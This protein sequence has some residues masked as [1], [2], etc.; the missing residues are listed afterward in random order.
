MAGWVSIS[1]YA[2]DEAT[3]DET[4]HVW[5]IHLQGRVQGVGFRPYVYNKAVAL[6]LAGEVSNGL[7]GV[8]IRLRTNKKVAWALANDIVNNPPQQAVV[9]SYYLEPEPDKIFDG[10]NIVQ[11]TGSKEPNLW[12]TPDFALCDSCKQE[13]ENPA[14]RRFRYPFITCTNCGPRYSVMQALP[15][16]RHLTTM[17]PFTFCISCQQEFDNPADRRFYAQTM[18]CPACGVQMVFTDAHGIV[19]STGDSDAIIQSVTSA[20]QEGSI[21][22]VKG[23]GGF[24]LMTDA[25]NETA[26]TRLRQRKHRPA[27]P[28]A[29]M[30]PALEHLAKDTTLSKEETALLGSPEAPIV[31]L[32]ISPS[33][34]ESLATQ[35]LCPGLDKVGIMLPYAP[36]LHLIVQSFGKPLVATSGNVSGAP[37]CYTNDSAL[38]YLKDVADYFLLHNRDIVA[39]QDDSVVSVTYEKYPAI[40]LRRSR[41]YAPACEVYQTRSPQTV[42]ATGALMK[43]SFAIAHRHRVY[44]SQYLGNTD[45]YEAQQA[46][47]HTLGHMQQLL[48]CSP[49]VVIA[50]AHPNYFS[51]HLAK[52]L[53][54]A[55]NIPVHTVQHHKA[56]FAAALAE[57]DFANEHG[58]GLGIIWDGT[59]LGDDGNSWGGEFFLFENNRMQRVNHFANTPYF[60]GDKMA[61]EPR[62]SALSQLHTMA[63]K[64]PELRSMFTEQEWH[65]YHQMLQQYKGIYTSSVGRLFDA[66]A[67]IITGIGRQSYEGEAAMRLEAMANS[68]C[69]THGFQQLE[70]F[71]PYMQP[72]APIPSNTIL[73]NIIQSLKRGADPS[74]IAARFHATLRDVVGRLAEHYQQEHLFF[75]GGV[76]QNALLVQ[77]LIDKYDR[78][79]HLHFHKQLSPNDENIS[80]G[81]LVYFDT[82]IL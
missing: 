35:A 62:I 64:P 26:I 73:F 23:I 4:E 47:L 2:H 49:E 20:L 33:M 25:T 42:L 44:V 53:S 3:D 32:N 22:A 41:G 29:I 11:D 70:T 82:Q 63:E 58:H 77:M 74:Y 31:L 79:Y 66:A 78:Q 34:R 18:S 71:L 37:I 65:L 7:D 9:T 40:L 72:D 54:Q 6:G 10:F 28:F 24:L 51:H 36:L 59:G 5:H 46:Y 61:A 27:K 8:H 21:I 67:C 52:E 38:T 30:Y 14:D 48:Q 76:F 57:Y 15:F 1:P 81:Q 69:R 43:S 39:P 75:S 12:I 68:W 16:E 55:N 13:L 19:Q 50:D 56:H 60:L 80:F 45:S 17:Q